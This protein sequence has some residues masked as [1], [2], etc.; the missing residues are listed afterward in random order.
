MIKLLYL[1]IIFAYRNI[2]TLATFTSLLLYNYILCFSYLF[3]IQKFFVSPF[4]MNTFFYYDLH[5]IF[6]ECLTSYLCSIFR[7]LLSFVVL[8]GLGYEPRIPR[9]IIDMLQCIYYEIHKSEYII[10]ILSACGKSI[11]T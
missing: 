11:C 8:W 9:C 1:E 2:F 6:C 10:Q 5:H 4:M 3:M 7:F